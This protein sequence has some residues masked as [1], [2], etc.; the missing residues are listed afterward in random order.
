MDTIPSPG[1]NPW[2]KS[3]TIALTD[4]G[5]TSFRTV[6]L[7]PLVNSPQRLLV[8]AFDKRCSLKAIRSDSSGYEVVEIR[9]N[10]D[11]HRDFVIVLPS[12]PTHLF[13]DARNI[14]YAPERGSRRSTFPTPTAS[15]AST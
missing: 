11:I 1:L 6:A 13:I 5:T 14:H 12:T 7:F 3:Y 8:P 15:E 9:A 10:G 2:M 4:G